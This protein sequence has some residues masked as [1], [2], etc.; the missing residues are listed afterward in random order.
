MHNKTSQQYNDFLIGSLSKKQIKKRQVEQGEITKDREYFFYTYR[1]K[2]RLH[3]ILGKMTCDDIAKTVK[4]K[5]PSMGIYIDLDEEEIN[6]TDVYLS[7]IKAP[8]IIKKKF[9]KIKKIQLQLE[10]EAKL[11]GGSKNKKTKS[12]KVSNKSKYNL[13]KIYIARNGMNYIKN[14]LGQTRFIKKR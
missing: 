5:I 2:L 12:K 7:K 9:N 3:D 13:K 6:Y 14:G 1:S 8:P 10:N 11:Q 4:Y